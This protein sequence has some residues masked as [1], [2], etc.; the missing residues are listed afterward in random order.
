MKSR[1]RSKCV[2]KGGKLI[3]ST[4][5]WD[6]DAGMTEEMRT[7]EHAHDYR[8]FPEPD[9]MPFEPTDAWLAEVKA[10]VVELP[11]ARKQR[12]MRDYQLPAADAQTF[13]WDV[14]LGNYFEGIAKQS[15]NPKAVANWVI[16]NLRA[17]LTEVRRTAGSADLKIQARAP[18]L[19]LDRALVEAARS[20]ARSRRRCSPKCSRPASRPP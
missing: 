9:L 7:K 6:D 3:Q 11:L 13:V 17:K 8:Y 10:R 19:E 2:K 1:A 20:A 16:N 14:P 4:R 12:F 18:S 15:K 5:R